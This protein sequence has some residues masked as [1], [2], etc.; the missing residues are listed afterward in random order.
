M[1]RRRRFAGWLAALAVGAAACAPV[2][3][4]SPDPWGSARQ[5]D[6][7][8][9]WMD[10]Y[11]FVPPLPPW[12]VLDLNEAEVSLAFFKSCAAAGGRCQATLG[13]AEEPF[14][15]SREL[16]PRAREFF[17]RHLWAARV[18][19]PPPQL[20]AVT[21]GGREALAAVA[22]A[23]E[24]VNGEKVMTRA[25]FLHRGERVVA[26]FMNQWRGRNVPFDPA[27]F[28]ELD[29]FAASLRFLKPSFYEQL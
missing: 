13:Y 9:I 25:L 21:V 29:R 1:S 23:T 24:P 15:S 10:E 16:A 4:V 26:L 20:E 12:Q 28:A 17:R 8:V 19:F 14:G 11:R 7:S 6:G 2:T 3:A 5:G 27:E 18:T 22:E